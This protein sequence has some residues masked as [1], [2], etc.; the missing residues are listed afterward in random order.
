MNNLNIS[1]KKNKT[2][3]ILIFGL[4]LLTIMTFGSTFLGFGKGGFEITDVFKQFSFYFQFGV[5]SLMIILIITALEF[6]INKNDAKYGEGDGFYTP[7][8][9]PHWK[10]T[11]FDNPFRVILAFSII[12]SIMGVFSG[13]TS[14]TYFG[15]GSMG[16][17]FTKL[18]GFL[19]NLFLVVPSEN[20]GV[21]ALLAV[22]LFFTRY[23]ARKSNIDASNFKIYAWIFGV[24]SFSVYG[25]TYHLLRYS[26]TDLAISNVLVVWTIG[27]ILTMLSGSAIPFLILHAVNNG[28]YELGR[29]F[30]KDAVIIDLYLFIAVMIGLYLYYYVFRRPK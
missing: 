1:K 11:F 20:L 21:A 8:Q 4:I 17:Q 5:G 30:S 27:G 7:N 6:F 13:V 28:F 24:L 10:S 16:Q 23:W 15:V 22:V 3:S 19:F 29:S 18:D 2:V 9:Y 12:F 25:V 14:Q 26:N